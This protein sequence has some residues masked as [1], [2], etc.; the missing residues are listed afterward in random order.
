MLG[1]S[2]SPPPDF[3]MPTNYT[4]T[5]PAYS[6]RHSP[7]NIT[8]DSEYGY[9]PPQND[10]PIITRASEI[11]DLPNDDSDLEHDREVE[12]INLM[13]VY[14]NRNRIPIQIN[15]VYLFPQD[16]NIHDLKWEEYPTEAC[17]DHCVI[18]LNTDKSFARFYLTHSLCLK[19]RSTIT[20]LGPWLYLSNKASTLPKLYKS[21]QITQFITLMHQNIRRDQ[22]VKD[23]LAACHLVENNGSFTLLIRVDVYMTHNPLECRYWTQSYIVN[24]PVLFGDKTQ[25]YI[26]RD[27]TDMI[28]DIH[29][30]G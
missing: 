13:G 24:D 16:N 22:M 14:V 2:D 9:T 23:Y 1:R 10:S 3:V 20:N 19:L 27:F 11:F 5:S 12:L 4:P 26:Q 21:P 29:V 8:S 28:Y 25:Y 7:I 17:S 6:P 15:G 30:D 18:P